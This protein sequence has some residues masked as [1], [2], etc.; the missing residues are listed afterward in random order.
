L[1]LEHQ[2]LE[3]SDLLA[4]KDTEASALQ[5]ELTEVNKLVSKL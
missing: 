5:D 4:E 2:S 3:F 1:Q